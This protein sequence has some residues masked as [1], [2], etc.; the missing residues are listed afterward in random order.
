MRKL[1]GKLV[2]AATAV[3]LGASALVGCTTSPK[4]DSAFEVA[5]IITELDSYS[6]NM[7]IKTES[8]DQEFDMDLFGKCSKEAVSLGF[9]YKD[10]DN[11]YEVKE[12]IIATPTSMYFNLKDAMDEFAE[13]MDLG[14]YGVEADWIKIE[15]DA[16]EQKEVDNSSIETIIKDAEK[17]YK[18]VI[19]NKDG[20]YVIEI[21]DKESAVAFVD[22][23]SALLEDKAADWSEIFADVYSDMLTSAEDSDA[24]MTSMITNILMDINKTMD[25]GYTKT[26]IEEIVKDKV[27]IDEENSDE[28]NIFTADFIETEMKELAEILKESV[29]NSEDDEEEIGGSLKYTAYQKKNTYVTEISMEI[30]DDVKTD[31]YDETSETKITYTVVDEKVKI[32]IPSSNVMTLGEAIGNALVK[33]GI[34]PDFENPQEGFDVEDIFSN[35]LLSGITGGMNYDDYYGSG[36]DFD[37]IFGDEYFEWE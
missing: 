21:D 12:L 27:I 31:Y 30:E 32:N 19:K 18:D 13:G 3:A 10:E 8:A 9:K 25:A 37:D 34:N 15:W 26:E 6:F 4:A 16:V 29:E 36:T 5:G 7:C 11:K 20:K 24:V 17:A 23:T 33:F 2:A 1:L 14:V 22:A 35:G 28:E